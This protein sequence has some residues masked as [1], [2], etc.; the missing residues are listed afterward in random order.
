MAVLMAV[1]Q[2]KHEIVRVDVKNKKDS[3]FLKYIIFNK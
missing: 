3:F 1:G 2:N